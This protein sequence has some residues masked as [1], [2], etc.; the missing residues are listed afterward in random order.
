MKATYVDLDRDRLLGQVTAFLEMSLISKTAPE[1]VGAAGSHIR[2]VPASLLTAGHEFMFLSDQESETYEDLHRHLG[3]LRETEWL[4]TDLLE[5]RLWELA[6]EVAIRPEAFADANARRDHAANLLAGV[7]H[8]LGE[9]EVIFTVNHITPPANPLEVWDARLLT[10]TAKILRPFVEEHERG[11]HQAGVM[12]PFLGK[13]ALIL[14]EHGTGAGPVI[15]R[16]RRRATHRLHV[17]R[18]SLAAHWQ[19]HPAQFLFALGDEVMA[20]ALSA[21]PDGL[22]VLTRPPTAPI[23]LDIHAGLQERLEIMRATFE[24]FAICD[25]SVQSA[26]ERAFEW[27]GRGLCRH[28]SG[29]ALR[30]YTTASEVLLLIAGEKRKSVLVP[31]RMLTL[32]DLHGEPMPHPA[33]VRH[34]YHRRSIVVHDGFDEAGDEQSTRRMLAVA[35]DCAAWLMSFATGMPGEEHA[36]LLK[37]LDT[38]NT[39]QK[40]IAWLTQFSDPWS[41]VLVKGIRALPKR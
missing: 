23:D 41:Q 40:A 39:R 1:K 15:E 4:G 11:D 20:R 36:T 33:V 24:G 6:C 22:R 5:G 16:A 10:A 29:D 17:L 37:A 19:V 13:T 31:Y 14:R 7:L 27:I 18:G 21:P 32:A 26:V 12:A 25:P 3:L 38:P 28:W 35:S 8:P 9:Y 34:A 2:P 30:D